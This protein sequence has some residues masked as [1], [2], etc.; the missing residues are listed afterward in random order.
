M[1]YFEELGGANFRM[2]S[3]HRLAR[4]YHL[5]SVFGELGESFHATRVALNDMTERLLSVGEPVHG[6][7]TVL[8]SAFGAA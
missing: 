8:K 1:K 2:A 7:G 3:D 4:R 6:S 5:E